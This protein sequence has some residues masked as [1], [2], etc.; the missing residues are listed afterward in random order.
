M[1][2]KKKDGSA[3]LKKKERVGN[4]TKRNQSKYYAK[5]Q[6][7]E[8]FRQKIPRLSMETMENTFREKV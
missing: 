7:Q 6:N 3:T 2:K 1:G 8:T 5:K 4:K